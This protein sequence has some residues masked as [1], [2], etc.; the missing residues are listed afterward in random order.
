MRRKRALCLTLLAATAVA[1]QAH[2]H[3]WIDGTFELQLDPRGLT[4]IV[5]T[6]VFD[7]FNSA[8]MI[9]MFDDDLDGTLSPA[10]VRRIH[11]EA[12]VHL[13]QLDYFVI[14]YSGQRQLAIPEAEQFD[15][16]IEGRRLVYEF[17]L[18]LSVPW[19]DLNDLIVAF[20]DES[21]FIDF[22]SAPTVDRYDH[23]GRSVRLQTETLR[24]A[25]QGWGTIN[26]PAIRTVLR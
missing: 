20:F 24:L 4:G 7:Q 15:A 19:Q 25:S 26:V 11:D 6:W 18:P 5:A 12:F 9:F 3:M 1:L 17:T 13:V 22:M 10:E 23:A 16:R 2:P 8:D 14:A 21:F